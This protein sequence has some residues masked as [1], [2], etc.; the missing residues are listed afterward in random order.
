[1]TT[2]LVTALDRLIRAVR[3]RRDIEAYRR[4][5]PTREEIDLAAA[6]A[7]PHPRR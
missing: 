7:L 6:G 3:L 4:I 2:P 1:V 5:P